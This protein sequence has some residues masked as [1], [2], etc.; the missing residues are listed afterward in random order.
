MP[1]NYLPR[2]TGEHSDSLV[3]AYSGDPEMSA[4]N[5]MFFPIPQLNRS[6]ADIML[7]FLSSQGISFMRETNDPWYSAH[8]P[9]RLRTN[10]I[11]NISEPS[12]LADD[13]VS[14]LGCTMQMQLCNPNL[15]T[16]S[17]SPQGQCNPLRGMAD[18]TFPRYDLWAASPSRQRFVK[19]LDNVMGLGLFTA[20]GIFDRLGAAAL[21]SRY[22]LAD[23]YQGPL[24]D[25]QWQREVEF[26]V[27]A[28]LASI[29]GSLVEAANGPSPEMMSF[30]VAPN[31]SEEWL[32]CRNQ[33]CGS[34]V[35][36]PQT[37]QAD[38][39]RAYKKIISTRYSSFSVLGIALTLAI[40]GIIMILDIA[41]EPLLSCVDR[42]WRGG[43]TRGSRHAFTRLEWRANATLQLQRMAHEH[44]GMG[45]WSNAA[46]ANPVTL[47][48]QTLALLDVSDENHPL[49]RAPT[50]REGGTPPSSLE[51]GPSAVE[52]ERID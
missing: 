21:T 22:L 45:T 10:S 38:R 4:A 1:E 20:S 11:S 39:G 44:A 24:P 29:Q 18:F 27:G 26:W 40:G 30:K 52:V 23:N 34:A 9:G 48:N 14:V 31:S 42:R 47:S 17:S 15:A 41:L 6:D 51:K 19:W 2:L 46:G 43:K 28:S 37:G 25:N 49:L 35:D 3:K 5:S 32:A 33:V 8:R 7:F 36:L 13:L 16:N 50:T 12:F